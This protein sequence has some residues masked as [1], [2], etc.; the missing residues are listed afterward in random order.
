MIEYVYAGRLGPRNCNEL[1]DEESLKTAF[2]AKI[3]PKKICSLRTGSCG[4][5]DE[6]PIRTHFSTRFGAEDIE[7]LVNSLA[8]RGRRGKQEGLALDYGRHGRHID[9]HQLRL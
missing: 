5:V 9:T 6:M 1:L 3:G 4:K 2:E 7:C 8:H